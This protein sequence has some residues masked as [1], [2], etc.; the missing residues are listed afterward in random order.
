MK[1]NWLFSSDKKSTVIDWKFIGSILRAPTF[2][3]VLIK[4]ISKSPKSKQKR[5]GMRLL[6]SCPSLRYCIRKSFMKRINFLGHII[7]WG[8]A[9]SIV[10]SEFVLFPKLC[11]SCYPNPWS[12]FQGKMGRFKITKPFILLKIRVFI[13]NIFFLCKISV[14]YRKANVYNFISNNELYYFTN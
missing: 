6:K 10:S 3:P 13:F 4:K 5:P 1:F 14:W 2:D 12:N 11:R 7:S 9:T 8:K